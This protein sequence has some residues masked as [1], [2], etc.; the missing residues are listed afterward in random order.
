MVVGD[1]LQGVGDALDQV[2]LLNLGHQ[3]APCGMN[4]KL[5][6][7]IGQ[8]RGHG[9]HCSGGD[10]C[11]AGVRIHSE[12]RCGRRCQAPA[13]RRIAYFDVRTATAPGL[14]MAPCD[15]EAT[16]AVYLA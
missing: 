7:I 16:R 6:I 15:A 10:L 1:E 13:P 12:R 14:V 11:E 5:C 8:K 9:R 2:F 3:W 4:W